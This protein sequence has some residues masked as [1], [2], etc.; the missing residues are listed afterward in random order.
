MSAGTREQSSAQRPCGKP[1]HFGSHC[2]APSHSL[3][4]QQAQRPCRWTTVLVCASLFVWCSPK[5]YAC[6]CGGFQKGQL[7]VRGMPQFLA[8]QWP[9]STFSSQLSLTRDVWKDP[10]RATE[11]QGEWRRVVES[12][13]KC[14]LILPRMRAQI[15]NRMPRHPLMAIISIKEGEASCVDRSLE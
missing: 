6:T 2:R 14:G 12:P 13:I 3:V 4:S 15:W 5:E 7:G 10:V 9:K 8:N 1:S 11:S